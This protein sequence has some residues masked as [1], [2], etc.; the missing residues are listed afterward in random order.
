MLAV[1]RNL[2]AII[3][4]VVLGS[5]INLSIVTIGMSVIPAPEGIDM[6]DMESLQANMNALEPKNFIFPWLAHALGTLI[7]AFSTARLAH[8][9]ARMLAMM[10]GG[11][12]LLGG[13]TMVVAVGGP[14]WFV[15]FDLIG[16]YIPMAFIGGIMA[17]RRHAQ[18]VESS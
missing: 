5:M 14:T 7:G 17:D 15:L 3:L 9:N 13:I 1:L 8:S 16:A 10:V 2:F 12:F 11:F 6:S 18:A 4:G